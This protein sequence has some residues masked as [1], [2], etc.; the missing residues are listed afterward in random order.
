MINNLHLACDVTGFVPT[1]AHA[2]L[3]VAERLNCIILF[4]EPGA[5][6]QGLIAEGHAMKGFRVDTKSCNWGP[7]SG[8]VCMDPRLTKDTVYEGRN[9]EWTHEALSGAINEKF[10]G[11]V[12]DAAWKGGAMPIVLSPK[13]V[14]ELTQKGV[15]TPATD[16][17]GHKI[18]VSKAPKGS[19][20]LPWRLIPVGNRQ[21]T[22][23]LVNGRVVKQEIHWLRGATPQHMVL[24]VDTHKTGG[25]AQSYPHGLAD[26]V[27]KTMFGGYET[28]MGL[29]NPN[30]EHLGFK[31][32][33]TADY[34]LLA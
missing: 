21:V 2:A 16:M 10:F 4:R 20:S 18:G 23:N 17:Y 28:I 14:E 25:F 22:S 31:A 32:C 33:V 15:I 8:F 19:A 5:A 6:V 27:S 13:R 7:M 3:S 34:D 12:T 1:H 11:K 29:T 24:C 26:P 9:K 30:T